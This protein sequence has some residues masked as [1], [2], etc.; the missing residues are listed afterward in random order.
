MKSNFQNPDTLLFG[1]GDRVWFRLDREKEGM[2][3][4]IVFRPHGHVYD[5]TWQ[6]MDESEH[7]ECELT[8]S[9]EEA[10]KTL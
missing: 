1:L 7:Y 3:T 9:P 5:V 4:G 6:D 2:I 8:A 10:K